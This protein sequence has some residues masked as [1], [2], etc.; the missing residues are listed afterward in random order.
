[1]KRCLVLGAGVSGRAAARLGGRLGW[2]VRVY[3]ARPEAIPPLN[4]S[5]RWSAVTGRWRPEWVSD[6]DLVVASQLPA[7]RV[8]RMV[9]TGPYD[10]L[11]DAHNTM[12]DW[13]RDRGLTPAGGPIEIYLNDPFDVTDASEYQTE[14]IWPIE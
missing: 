1:V 12:V 2:R 5:E 6:C 13:I 4:G 3:D 9:H 7:G 10:N 11:M 8:A 14:I